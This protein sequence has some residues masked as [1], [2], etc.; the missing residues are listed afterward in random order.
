MRTEFHAV[1]NR[2]QAFKL[3]PWAA[4]IIKR[5]GGYMGFE[6]IDDYLAYKNNY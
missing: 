2:Y 3:M 6:S 4:V 5:E 1:N